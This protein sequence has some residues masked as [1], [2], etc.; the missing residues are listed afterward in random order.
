M[1]NRDYMINKN[2]NLSPLVNFYQ[3]EYHLYIVGRKMKLPKARIVDLTTCN[4]NYNCSIIV[5]LLS[6][7]LFLYVH[8]THKYKQKNTMI[9]Q[10]EKNERLHINFKCNK[11]NKNNF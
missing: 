3:L 8:C 1:K 7:V 5:C 2:K 6:V 11:A 10:Q 4:M 9:C